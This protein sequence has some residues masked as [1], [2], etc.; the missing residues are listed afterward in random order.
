MLRDKGIKISPQNIKDGIAK[1]KVAGRLEILNKSPLIIIDGAHN[2][3][4]I[5]AL[6][7]T[8]DSYLK[9]KRIIAV[10]GCLRIKN[11]KAV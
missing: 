3:S 7:N 10:M 4:G 11:M 8:I 2:F 5:I 1:T 9:N 6:C